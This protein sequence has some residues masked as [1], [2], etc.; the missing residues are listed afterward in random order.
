VRRA[1]E[2]LTT[3]FLRSRLGVA[4]ALAVIVFGIVGAARL[5]PGSS[6]AGSALPGVP[7]QPITTVNPTAGADGAISTV[8]PPSPTTS[9]GGVPPDGVARAFAAAWVAHTGV[10]QQ[11]WHAALLPLSTTAL[12]AKFASVDS[13]GVPA[14]RV[15]GEPIVIPKT[16]GFV[17]VTMPVDSGQLRLGLVARDG[18]WLVDTVDWA[19]G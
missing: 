13:I 4:L 6:D 3:R 18:R 11:Q 9:P 10:S 2:F 7:S 8:E 1:I 5:F 19:R 17:E 12:T 14:S 15:T 16:A